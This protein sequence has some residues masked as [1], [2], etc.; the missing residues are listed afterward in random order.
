LDLG[1]I[2]ERVEAVGGCSQD[3]PV[4]NVRNTHAQTKVSQRA[5]NG[6]NVAQYT[7]YTT[8]TP[9]RVSYLPVPTTYPPLPPCMCP[10]VPIVGIN[11]QC[12]EKTII[13]RSHARDFD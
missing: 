10:M 5:Y 2:F 7:V 11:K 9:Y 13:I 6:T 1:L 8:H 12:I 3:T 4:R